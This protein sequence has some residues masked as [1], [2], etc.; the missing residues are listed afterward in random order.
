[1]T[2]PN[3]ND[4]VMEDRSLAL[5]PSFAHG[6]Y[7]LVGAA[8]LGCAVM[9]F[10]ARTLIAS[11]VALGAGS[12]SLALLFFLLNA[13]FAGAVQLSVGAGLVSTLFLIGISLTESIRGGRP[14]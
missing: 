2:C 3:M 13:P 14:R 11:A 1:M 9:A 6:L 5:P 7:V 10:R 12:T 8:L 4:V